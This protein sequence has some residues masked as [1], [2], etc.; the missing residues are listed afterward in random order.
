MRQH[1]P[2]NTM[3]LPNGAPCHHR[4]CDRKRDRKC[5]RKWGRNCDRNVCRN[6][7][8][9]WGQ[10]KEGVCR[11]WGR[12][13]DRNFGHVRFAHFTEGKRHATKAHGPDSRPNGVPAASPKQKFGR[14]NLNFGSSC[15]L[16]VSGGGG[17]GNGRGHRRG[18]GA[19]RPAGSGHPKKGFA[20]LGGCP[21]PVALPRR[22]PCA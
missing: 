7:G 4:K 17:P 13:C 6:L 10:K 9:N 22:K 21:N 16:V 11:K 5:D 3:A 12:N 2:T 19:A 20:C 8:R 1:M 14:R 18:P 15:M